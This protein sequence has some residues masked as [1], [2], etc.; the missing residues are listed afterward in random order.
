MQTERASNI[1]DQIGGALHRIADF[2]GG[3]LDVT[4][5]QR[6]TDIA[7]PGRCTGADF[8]TDVGDRRDDSIFDSAAEVPRLDA[9]A[10]GGDHFATDTNTVNALFDTFGD[11]I[12]DDRADATAWHFLFD[13]IS[14][15]INDDLRGVLAS[16]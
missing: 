1:G 16:V 11:A 8:V 15:A 13:A 2:P 10:D 14:D 4:G 3:T 5:A 12:N 7:S 9:S 6:I